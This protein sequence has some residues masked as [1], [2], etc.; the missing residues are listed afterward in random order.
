MSSAWLPDVPLHVLAMMPLFIIAAYVVF[1]ATGFGSSLIAVPLLA[2]HF[3][4]TFAV[5]LVAGL[6][7]AATPFASFR[8]WKHVRRDE[9]ARI[10][11]AMLV[12]L[13]VGAT[14]LVSIPRAPALFGL[15]VFV[16][17][18]G[19]Y[20]LVRRHSSPSMAAIWAMPLGFVGGIFS[21]LF[22]TGGPVYM[23]YFSA[24]IH[25]KAALRA[26]SSAMLA[27]SVYVRMIA[28]FLTGLLA[29]K[30]LL[31]SIAVMI[32]V[33]AVGY[34][35]GNRLHHALSRQGVMR[36]IAGLLIANGGL[37]VGRAVAAF[38]A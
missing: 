15:G 12:G 31:V 19:I 8:H 28:F 22:G 14:L 23:V 25:D 33:M 26:T 37:L 7:C 9:L 18:Y 4:L 10:V 13:A 27:V 32:P 20:T 38:S 30:A 6:D 3:P 16:V 34:L 21:A 11:P 35:L 36:V 29:N 1:G 17:S 24:R 5:P 2:H